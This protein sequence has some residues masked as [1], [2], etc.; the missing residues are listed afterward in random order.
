MKYRK[1]FKIQKIE[2][3]LAGHHD[4]QIQYQDPENMLY[5]ISGESQLMEFYLL[6]NWQ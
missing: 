5:Q 2:V 6:I 1:Y 3:D 4:M